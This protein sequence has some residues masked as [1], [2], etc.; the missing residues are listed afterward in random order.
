MEQKFIAA[1]MENRE[2]A[3]R[4]GVRLRPVAPEEAMKTA[5]RWLS[6]HRESD[7]FHILAD[8]HHLELTD[9]TWWE[10]VAA[11]MLIVAVAGIG[12]FP[13]FFNN[14]INTTFTEKIFTVLGMN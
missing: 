10:R 5:K 14:L 6:G 7:G 2:T 4:M 13:N 8:K 11:I 1:W 12:C 9:A 3:A